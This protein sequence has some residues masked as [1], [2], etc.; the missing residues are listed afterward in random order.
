MLLIF[1]GLFANQF[2]TILIKSY[3]AKRGKGGMFF[4]AIVCLFAMIYFFLSD[5]G[6]L[7]FPLGIVVYGL[8][9][10]TMYATG[11]Y[12]M[13]VALSLGS[14]GLTK[15]FMSFGI[16]IS[17]FYGIVFLNEPTSP[18]TYIA[19]TMIMLS[20]FMMNYQKDDGGQKITLK[21]VIYMLLV[22]ASN[23]IISIIGRMQFGD[24]GD[25][26]NNEFLIISLGGGALYLFIMGL[27]FERDSL[28]STFKNGFLYGAGA[29][30]FNGIN[31]LLT[32]VT[33]NYLAISFT[34]PVR[35]GLG[36]ILSFLVSIILYREKFSKRQIISVIIGIV[37][38]I[39]MNL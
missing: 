39:L 4:N 33:Y 7:Q 36:M 34:S 19:F 16:I 12:T 21:W 1:L 13:Y 30:V 18:L 37:A 20:L 5:K 9:N 38:V 3:G 26:F 29:G 2:E 25:Q 14:F 10:S 15:L 8:I 24:Y 17:T 6:G 22:V 27:I 31:N 11:F 28:K 35:A 32:L 23:A